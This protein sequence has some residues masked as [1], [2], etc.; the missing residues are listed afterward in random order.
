MRL[1]R[2]LKFGVLICLP[3]LMVNYSS[4]QVEIPYLRDSVLQSI[5]KGMVAS[6]RYRPK[7][8]SGAI[9]LPFKYASPC[10]VGSD[11]FSELYYWDA[12]FANRYYWM[13]KATAGNSEAFEVAQGNVNNLIYLVNK[14]GFVPNANRYSML[15]RSQLPLLSEMVKD[16]FEFS[17]DVNWLQNAVEALEKEHQFW[18]QN[19]A[20]QVKLRGDLVTLNRFG[21]LASSEQLIGFYR[22]LKQRLKHNSGIILPVSVAI[23]STFFDTRM[24]LVSDQKSRDSQLNFTS[25]L[26]AEAESG[27]DF[28]SRFHGVC[29]DYLPVDLNAVLGSMERNMVDFYR[30]LEIFETDPYKKEIDK[31]RLLYY[32]KTSAMRKL[33]MDKYLWDKKYGCYLD[34]QWHSSIDEHSVKQKSLL[35]AASFWPMYLHWGKASS[36][37]SVHQML[38]FLLFNGVVMPVAKNEAQEMPYRCQWNAPNVWAPLQILVWESIRSISPRKDFWKISAISNSWI[39]LVLKQWQTDGSFK[40]KYTAINNES[41]FQLF[42]Q[43]R[44]NGT[45]LNHYGG[46][47]MVEEGYGTPSMMGW[48]A[49]ITYFFLQLP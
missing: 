40:E 48:T 29:M 20:V 10:P 24:E 49:A 46:D 45:S 36:E 30:V 18:M 47:F 41:D 38:N 1:Q 25:H 42:H 6:I 8:S 21:N 17:G 44:A 19:R 4:A 31:F 32:Q 33:A 43:W 26:L 11:M 37:N 34:Y 5:D 9:G 15:N 13:P 22:F 27:W 7:D 23:P 2:Y 39:Q 14:Y 12:F 28:T 3:L 16:I 35:T